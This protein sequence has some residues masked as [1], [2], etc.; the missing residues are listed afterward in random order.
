MPFWP[1]RAVAR[2]GV[3]GDPILVNSWGIPLLGLGYRKILMPT[4]IDLREILS[5]LSMRWYGYGKVESEPDYH[6]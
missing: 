1:T 4:S 3:N 5:P 6:G 2:S